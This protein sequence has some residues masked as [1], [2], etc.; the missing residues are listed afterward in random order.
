MGLRVQKLLPW[1]ALISLIN[2][3]AVGQQKMTLTYDR[4]QF[5]EDFLNA[6]YP[7]L[8]PHHL[9]TI[10]T[11]FSWIGSSYFYVGITPCHPG[12]G[13]PAGGTPFPPDECS[14][15]PLQADAS[16]FFMASVIL[17]HKKPYLRGFGAGGE[18]LSGR[19]EAWSRDII[20]HLEWTEDQR[21]NALRLMKPRFGPDEKEAF[22]GTIPVQT[23]ERF[24]GCRLN[25]DSAVFVAKRLLPRADKQTQLGWTVTGEGGD[26]RSGCSA[27]FEPFEGRLLRL[28]P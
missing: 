7:G 27:E 12:S 11:V 19:L 13:V 22:I 25:P 2:V 24:S 1:L 21:L 23:I 4:I 6:M 8:G 20:R 28:S 26:T 3:S 14:A 5:A 17:S 18:F 9:I 10:Q 15:P 16:S